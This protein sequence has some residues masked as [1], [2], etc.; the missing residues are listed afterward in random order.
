MTFLELAGIFGLSHNQAVVLD[1]Y[2]VLKINPKNVVI[3]ST[4]GD[5]LAIANVTMGVLNMA[6][7]GKIGPA[8]KSMIKGEV[9]AAFDKA[10][11]TIPDSKKGETKYPYVGDP[12][13]VDVQGAALEWMLGGNKVGA[14]KA[15]RAM[16]GLGLKPAKE[17][18]ELWWAAHEQAAQAK[19]S[20][21]LDDIEAE[22]AMEAEHFTPKKKKKKSKKKT[23]SGKPYGETEFA[24][25]TKKAKAM[26]KGVYVSDDTEGVM[27]NV[28]VP[29]GEAKEVF[30]P[31]G[32]TDSTSVYFAIA[33]GPEVNVGCRVTSAGKISIRAEG[34]GCEKNAVTKQLAAAGLSSA[35][36]GHWSVHLN[37]PDESL[38]KK[39][40]GA[41]LYALSLPFTQ[42]AG[43]VSPIM[44]KGS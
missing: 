41:I 1:G 10:W 15:V 3:E 30:Q 17:L 35:S 31:V 44:G 9:E 24:G 19:A 25:L 16:T 20:E 27:D 36:A 21:M 11:A 5:C 37:V 23:V 26:P 7:T 32:G 34:P 8:T 6:Q 13:H 33:I 4:N 14:I 38:T 42:I 22:E 40:I 39:T 2:C 29:L 12:Q 28:A 18:V 43:D